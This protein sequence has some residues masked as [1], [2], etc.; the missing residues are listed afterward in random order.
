MRARAEEQYCTIWYVCIPL[1]D[2]QRFQPDIPE[3]SIKCSAERELR[4]TKIRES[5]LILESE[6]N[7]GRVK[8]PNSDVV[9]FQIPPS[10]SLKY[11]NYNKKNQKRIFYSL[12]C[13]IIFNFQ[14]SIRYIPNIV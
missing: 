14:Q 4:I 7:L 12:F 9:E 1:N 10:F 6:Q 8:L 13:Y 5:V 3:K 2:V 11:F